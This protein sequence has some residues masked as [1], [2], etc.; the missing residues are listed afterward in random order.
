MEPSTPEFQSSEFVH[1]GI[2]SDSDIHFYEAAGYKAGVAQPIEH[3]HH[4]LHRQI[5]AGSSDIQDISCAGSHELNGNLS[6]GTFDT[7]KVQIQES[8]SRKQ[9][10]R[11]HQR[12]FR[13]REKARNIFS[14][15]VFKCLS[16][17]TVSILRI[18]LGCAT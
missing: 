10:N 3:T 4:V 2:L 15:H 16:W 6:P 18:R 12:R 1:F 14:A 5:A 8:G 13:Q 7:D 11:E 9:A 17:F